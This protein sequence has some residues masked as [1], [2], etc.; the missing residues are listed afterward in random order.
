MSEAF[1]QAWALL[2]MA[3]HIVDD[4]VELWDYADS[5]KNSFGIDEWKGDNQDPFPEGYENLPRFFEREQPMP[6][7]FG[8]SNT[9]KTIEVDSHEGVPKENRAYGWGMGQTEGKPTLYRTVLNPKSEWRSYRAGRIDPTLRDLRGD[10]Y[11]YGRGFF[12]DPELPEGRE[13]PLTWEEMQDIHRQYYDNDLF[14]GISYPWGGGIGRGDY[15]KIMLTPNEFLQLALTGH[16]EQRALEMAEKWKQSDGRTPIGMPFLTAEL[17]YEGDRIYPEGDVQPLTGGQTFKITGH[18]G[19]HRMAA[20]RALGFGDK[21]LP[22][23]FELDDNSKHAFGRDPYG[24][25]RGLEEAL[26]GGHSILY[27]QSKDDERVWYRRQ[28]NTTWG[29]GEIERL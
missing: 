22:V 13:K 27:P 17:R 16:D 20:L 28:P 6:E 26:A 4:N 15:A 9:D 3:R 25:N 1:H 10:G 14:H 5:W 8:W 21:P 12:P 19:R 29:L 18:E 24:R 7:T 2:K 11:V 23:H